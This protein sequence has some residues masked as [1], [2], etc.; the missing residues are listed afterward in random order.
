MFMHEESMGLLE[1]PVGRFESPVV[2]DMGAEVPWEFVAVEG[3]L[4]GAGSATF[5]S[6]F[7]APFAPKKICEELV[8]RLAVWLQVE[9]AA[10]VGVLG[11]GLAGYGSAG[12]A[13]TVAG[14]EAGVCLFAGWVNLVWAEL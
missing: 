2:G 12:L 7:P 1:A 9:S 5:V 6:S 8:G 14:V 10:R 13:V 11:E 4:V 3:W